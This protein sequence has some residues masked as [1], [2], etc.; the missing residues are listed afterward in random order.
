MRISKPRIEC[1]ERADVW[2]QNFEYS[3]V[4]DGKQLEQDINSTCLVDNE[5][6]IDNQLDDASTGLNFKL[7]ENPSFQ[8]SDESNRCVLRPFGQSGYSN[9]KRT[10]KKSFGRV[11]AD[12]LGHDNVVKRSAGEAP[13]KNTKERKSDRK[14]DRKRDRKTDKKKN[15]Q[16]DK[17]KDEDG[18]SNRSGKTKEN[19]FVDELMQVFKS[20][21]R[22][23]DIL[24]EK[25]H[26]QTVEIG[27][28]SDKGI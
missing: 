21:D 15:K 26:R 6:D 3:A 9:L 8:D 20:S 12:M 24:E 16:K 1:F 13:D 14:K 23:I 2:I 7:F 5:N 11:I 19:K 10:L 17:R 4:K 27:L 28:V 25:I 22:R 18:E